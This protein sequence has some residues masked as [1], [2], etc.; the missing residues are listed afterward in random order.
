MADKDK[1]ETKTE[2]APFVSVIVPVYN[3]E[4]YIDECVRSMLAQDYPKDRMEWFLW[5]VCRR[6]ARWKYLRGIARSIRG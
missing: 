1:M 2:G 5:T 4:R 3:E 6:T